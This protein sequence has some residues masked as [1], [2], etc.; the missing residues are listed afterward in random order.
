MCADANGVGGTVPGADKKLITESVDRLMLNRHHQLAQSYS[1]QMFKDGGFKLSYAASRDMHSVL[2]FCVPVAA[3]LAV[4]YKP[5]YEEPKSALYKVVMMYSL[6]FTEKDDNWEAMVAAKEMWATPELAEA[7]TLFTSLLSV[8]VLQ[9]MLFMPYMAEHMGEVW[10]AKA[11]EMMSGIAR[12]SFLSTED[13]KKVVA[14]MVSA[15]IMPA[16]AGIT[17][18]VK[19]SG[20]DLF[21][22]WLKRLADTGEVV[23]EEKDAK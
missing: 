4:L 1:A 22:K 16:T 13:R 7:T 10:P 2:R 6:C 11:E 5:E 12:A 21:W 19:A 17:K 15:G 20:E 23:L 8:V 3:E 9:Y 18:L 14:G